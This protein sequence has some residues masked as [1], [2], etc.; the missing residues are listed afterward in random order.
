VKALGKIPAVDD[1]HAAQM[2]IMAT[3]HGAIGRLPEPFEPHEPPTTFEDCLAAVMPGSPPRVR[4][5][6]AASSR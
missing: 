3:K 6:D 1:D 2:T 5:R 4:D